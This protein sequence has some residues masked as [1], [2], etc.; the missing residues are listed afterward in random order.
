MLMLCQLVNTD[1][2]KN[3]D[4]FIFGVKL[5][6]PEA[7]GTMLLQIIKNHLFSDTQEPSLQCV[8]CRYLSVM[9]V[10]S[11]VSCMAVPLGN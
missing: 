10:V 8:N 9:P 1:V 3:H 6:D 7:T 4:A 2:L 11:E 5:L